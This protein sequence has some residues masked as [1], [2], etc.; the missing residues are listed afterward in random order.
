MA[1]PWHFCCLVCFQ[2][3][4]LGFIFNVFFEVKLVE[5]TFGLPRELIRYALPC[6]GGSD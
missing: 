6:G 1:W 4:L 3:P 5:W 2:R